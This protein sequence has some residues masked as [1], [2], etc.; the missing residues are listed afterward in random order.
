M[1]KEKFDLFFNYP[2]R[3]GECLEIE[4]HSKDIDIAK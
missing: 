4:E 2:N 1:L 3:K